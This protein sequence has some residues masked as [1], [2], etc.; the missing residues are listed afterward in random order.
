MHQAKPLSLTSLQANL[1]SLLIVGGVMAVLLVLGI[2]YR[3]TKIGLLGIGAIIGAGV[4]L[5]ILLRPQLGAYI[6]VVSVF[7][8]LSSNLTDLGLPGINKPLIALVFLGVMVNRFFI[9]RETLLPLK[10]TEIFM[11]AYGGVWFATFFIAADKYIVSEAV[12]DFAKDFA[13]LLC[14]VYPLE[15]RPDSWKRTI[16]LMILAATILTALGTYQT[17]SGNTDQDFFGFSKFIQAQIIKGQEDGGRLSG[18]IDDPNFWAQALVGVFPLV[19]YRIL[20]EKKLWLRAIAAVSAFL[21]AFSILST[22]SRGAFLAMILVLVL[23][24]IERR[25]KFS[26]VFLVTLAIFA[27]MPFLPTGFTDRLETL[28]IFTKEDA[29]VQS[30]ASFRGRTSEMLAAVNMFSDHPFLGVG[31]GNYVVYY[32]DYAS[33]LGLEQRTEDRQAHSLY[34][35]TAAETGI[36]GLVTFAG[37]I[38][39]LLGGLNQARHSLK[40]LPDYA[41][42]STWIISIQ[43]SILA[44]LISS[45]F[46]HSDYLRY[47]WL[48]VALGIAMIHLANNLQKT[49]PLQP[50]N[51]R[52][53][54]SDPLTSTLPLPDPC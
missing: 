17:F 10:A 8:N 16:W 25:V 23:I 36:F 37:L 40:K 30:E 12:V 19:L 9:K 6:L 15:S 38:I 48:L 42:W 3:T 32:Q 1:I 22:Y 20:D 34:L 2:G 39:A 35:E 18:P 13:L 4:G 14:L 31:K 46:L 33:R 41:H 53:V 27:L 24:A 26:L 7:T 51:Q 54:G 47:L 21:L 5:A 29:N 11:L 28:S 45:I 49:F 43:M 50:E 44:Y 52:Q